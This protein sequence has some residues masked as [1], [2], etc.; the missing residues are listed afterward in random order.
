MS[1]G[2]RRR[3]RLRLRVQTADDEDE[4]SALMF[5]PYEGPATFVVEGTAYPVDRIRLRVRTTGTTVE[6]VD[7]RHRRVVGLDGLELMAL[8]FLEMPELS[9]HGELRLDDG[10]VLDAVWTGSRF[11]VRQPLFRWPA[12]GCGR[13]P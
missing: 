1:A 7:H 9:V 12:G 10:Q 2:W 13:R 8:D 11:D 5:R 4:R 3:S 6:T